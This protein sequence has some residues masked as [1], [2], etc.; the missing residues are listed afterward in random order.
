MS[1]KP[2]RKEWTT[3]ELALLREHYPLH[4]AKELAKRLGRT[5]HS[6]QQAAGRYGISYQCRYAVSSLEEV[7]ALC[8]ID[9]TDDDACWVWTGAKVGT[10]PNI[11]VNG[12]AGSARVFVWLWTHGRKPGK[13]RVVR[14]TCGCAACLNPA[15]MVVQPRAQVLLENHGKAN[16]L[17]RAARQRRT[18]IQQG[19]AKL[20]MEQARRIR[21]ADGTLTELSAQ[22]GVS[23][24][25]V[26][27]IRAGIRWREAG[28][29]TGL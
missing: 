27:Q 22:F 25:L 9:P 1:G 20:T 18:A 19:R 3:A 24:A 15:H 17:I 26:H 6:V 14:M 28:F 10:L 7:R 2:S 13:S 23:R 16:P 8:E 29:A 5:A 12:A 11:K 21:A 4:G